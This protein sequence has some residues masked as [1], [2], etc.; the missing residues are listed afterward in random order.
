MRTSATTSNDELA[1][2]PHAPGGF[3]RRAGICGVAAP[4]HGPTVPASR[5]LASAGTALGTRPVPLLGQAPSWVAQREDLEVQHRAWERVWTARIRA[6]RPER[7]LEGVMTPQKNVA[8]APEL[9]EKVGELARAEGVTWTNSRTRP[10]GVSCSAGHSGRSWR[11]TARK[12][13]P[14][15]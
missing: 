9:Y 15:A 4:G 11:A 8:L 3:R 6:G 7:L 2:N 10:C 13:K 5:R 12:P 1:R 14:L